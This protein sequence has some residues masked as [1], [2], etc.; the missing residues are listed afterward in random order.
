MKTKLL[1]RT[2]ALGVTGCLLTTAAMARQATPTTPAQPGYSSQGSSS[3]SGWNRK[4]MMSGQNSK[5]L[6]QLMGATVK[7][8]DGQ[9]LGQINDFIVQPNFGRI[10][11]AVIS[12]AD[13]SGKLTAV[14]WQLLQPGTETTSFTLNVNKQKL[15]NAQTFDASTW[16]DFTQPGWGHS[17]Y[18]YYGVQPPNRMGGHIHTGGS[19]SGGGT[20]HQPDS[21]YP[22]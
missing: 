20:S 13:Q 4:G 19:E 14:P 5:R 16:P 12:L 10:Q 22:K 3:S 11:F 18:S 7:G 1:S 6:S 8:Q 21:S 15:D 9:T 17:I 2:L